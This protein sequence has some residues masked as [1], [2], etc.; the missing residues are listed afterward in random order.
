MIIDCTGAREELLAKLRSH[1][2]PE[3]LERAE[4]YEVDEETQQ[5]FDRMHAF[6]E[7]DIK[8]IEQQHN[9]KLVSYEHRSATPK[10]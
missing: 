4:H 5:M 6:L 7:Q 2:T 3:E 9:I 1:M 10:T 8:R